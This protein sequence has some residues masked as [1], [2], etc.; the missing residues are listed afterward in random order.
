MEVGIQD[1]GSSQ[2]IKHSRNVLADC[3][4]S[5]EHGVGKKH[6]EEADLRRVVLGESQKEELR[7]VLHEKRA[8]W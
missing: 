4:L 2:G 3:G 5:L 8:F 6:G 1:P 7:K